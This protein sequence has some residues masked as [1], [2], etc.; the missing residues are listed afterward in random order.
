MG[1]LL[2]SFG[3]LGPITTSLSLIIFRAYWPLSQPN[4]FTN[5]FFELPRPI[6]FLFTSLT[7]LLPLYLILFPWAYCFIPWASLAHLLLIYLFLLLWAF[8]PSILSF[9]PIGLVSLFLYCFP[10]FTFFI[11]RLLLLLGPLSKIGTNS[12]KLRGGQ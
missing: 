7:Y 3:F 4:E 2:D 11:V 1:F 6:Y 12:D 9:Q 10:L 8:W 5:S